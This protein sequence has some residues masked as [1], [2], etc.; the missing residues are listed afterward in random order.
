[1]A[2]FSTPKPLPKSEQIGSKRAPKSIKKVIEKLV[3]FGI[4]FEKRCGTVA[5]YARSALDN[6]KSQ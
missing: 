6:I 2:S 5:A 3:E 1:M 4:D